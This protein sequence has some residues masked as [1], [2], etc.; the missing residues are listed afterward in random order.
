M[1]LLRYA[2]NDT[3]L[4]PRNNIA[5]YVFLFLLS[6]GILLN[7]IIPPFQSPDEPKHFGA[8]MIYA[9]GEEQQ[10]TI[11]SNI[12]RF[13]DENEWWR[14]VGM[15][16][17][18]P[19]PDKLSDIDYLMDY[20]SVSDFRQLLQN[21]TFYHFFMGKILRLFSKNNI[22]AAYYICRLVSFLLMLGSF[23]LIFLSFQNKLGTVPNFIFGFF[24]AL[25]LPQLFLISLAV[26]PDALT[27]FVGSLF[28]FAAISL[29]SGKYGKHRL[30][31]TALLII[32]AV[33]GFF[34]DRSTFPLIIL[35]VL[36]P[37]FFIKKKNYQKTIVYSLAFL[38]L[39][40]LLLYFLT[41]L[42][43]LQIENSFLLLK[44]TLQRAVSGIP[45]LLS[46]NDFTGQFF[47]LTADSFLLKFGWMAYSGHKIFYIIW[48]LFITLSIIGV[49]LALGKFLLAR[50]KKQSKQILD[51]PHNKIIHFSLLA[52]CV[53][54]L[55][56]WSFYGTNNIFVQGRH[57][58]PLIL[59][60]SLLFVTGIKN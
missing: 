19:L 27:I 6:A 36:F 46:F 11:E 55:G 35:L 25:F 21:V 49:V 50:I 45:K 40:I 52:I 23:W 41:L 1:R 13:M 53:Q 59:P 42:F 43:P 38:I 57:L 30:G 8:I 22:H 33:L 18:F 34:T 29:L 9:Q 12:I 47:I 20:Y 16:R 37:L 14:F 44:N 51:F 2:R 48:R 10:E 24:F 56:L 32:P 3:T 58:F 54:I 5:T 31:Y 4:A 17:P 15:W 26:A 60:I 39:F 28:F 7:F